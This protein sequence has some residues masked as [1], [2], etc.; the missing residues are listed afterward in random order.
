MLQSSDKV[1]LKGHLVHFLKR[2][3]KRNSET[4]ETLCEFEIRF[5]RMARHRNRKTV[6]DSN[7]LEKEFSTAQESLK[8]VQWDASGEQ[9]FVQYKRTSRRIRMDA[10]GAVVENITKRR[11]QEKVLALQGLHHTL[12]LSL[13]SEKKENT[14]PTINSTWR[15]SCKTR[16]FFTK[17]FRSF[18][19]TTTRNHHTKERQIEIEAALSRVLTGEEINS[20]ASLLIT[21]IERLVAVL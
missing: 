16:A 3:Q 17:G 11:I 20:L 19:F 8:A 13:S 15:K 7:L 14:I 1:E 9:E 18:H 21:D 4:P 6:F 10:T 12:R 5:G 2:Q